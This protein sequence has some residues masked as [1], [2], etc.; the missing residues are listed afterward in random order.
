MAIQDAPDGTIWVTH[1]H[2]VVDTPVPEVPDHEEAITELARKTTSSTEYQKVVSWKVSKGKVGIL[3]FVEMES[4]DYEHT[5]FR[6]TIAAKEQFKDVQL[7]ASLAL[8]WPGPRLA[9]DDIVLLEAK[10]TDVAVEVKVDG[11]ILGKEVG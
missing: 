10:S 9:A 11:D 7:E 8:E 3:Q 5:R 1:V 4:N 6:L 2:V